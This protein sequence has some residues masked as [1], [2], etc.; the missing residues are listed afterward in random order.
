MKNKYT[1]IFLFLFLLNGCSHICKDTNILYLAKVPAENVIDGETNLSSR[2]ITFSGAIIIDENLDAINKIYDI[3]D[4]KTI[5][6]IYREY[7]ENGIFEN[8]SCIVKDNDKETSSYKKFEFSQIIYTEDRKSFLTKIKE[9]GFYADKHVYLPINPNVGKH[10]LKYKLS[11]EQQEGDLKR[12]ILSD[13]Y[14]WKEDI[15]EEVVDGIHFSTYPSLKRNI[16]KRCE[17]YSR[18]PIDTKPVNLYIIDYEWDIN[19][20]TGC[21]TVKPNTAKYLGKITIYRNGEYTYSHDKFVRMN[22]PTN[23]YNNTVV[24]LNSM[25]CKNIEFY[26][27]KPKGGVSKSAISKVEVI[28]KGKP[29]NKWKV[30][31]TTKFPAKEFFKCLYKSGYYINE[32]VGKKYETYQWE[33]EKHPYELIKAI[34]KEAGKICIP[35][36]D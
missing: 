26:N 28:Q 25:E 24:Q 32:S 21:K 23:A 7:K 13:Y 10:Y 16:D 19:S 27:N 35:D 17:S 4:Y 30:E 34:K 11:K 12:S 2:G 22:A 14:Y 8:M 1:T 15:R 31:T 5:D 9:I 29:I 20:K 33:K 6:T 36:T 3:N 18:K